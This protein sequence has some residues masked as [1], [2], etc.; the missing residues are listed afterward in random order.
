MVSWGTSKKTPLMGMAL[1]MFLDTE[2]SILF[3]S[4]G[5][6]LGSQGPSIFRYFSAFAASGSGEKLLHHS[7]TSLGNRKNTIS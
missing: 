1:S 5:D 6:I 7:E 2:T 3:T 4:E